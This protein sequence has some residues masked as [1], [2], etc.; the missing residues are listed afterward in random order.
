M[1]IRMKKKKK[2]SQP[3][4]QSFFL[5]HFYLLEIWCVISLGITLLSKLQEIKS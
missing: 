5:N 3:N 2:P 4:D 1:F